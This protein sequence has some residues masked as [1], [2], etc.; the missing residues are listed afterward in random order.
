MLASMQGGK[1]EVE[2]AQ[3]RNWCYGCETILLE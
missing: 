2:W 3:P 1:A